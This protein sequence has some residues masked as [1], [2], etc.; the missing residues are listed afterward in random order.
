MQDPWCSLNEVR[1]V[2]QNARQ[3]VLLHL[4]DGTDCDRNML[5][6]VLPPC[7]V[8]ERVMSCSLFQGWVP[9]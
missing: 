9:I 5:H 6:A 3:D 1:F 4:C 2:L 7:L 8:I